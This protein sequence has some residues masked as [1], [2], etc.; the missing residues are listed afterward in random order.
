ML[1]D[2]HIQGFEW[3]EAFPTVNIKNRGIGGDISKGL[4]ARLDEVLDSKP[5][6]VFIQIGVNDIVNG[7]DPDSIIT[8]YQKI[9][10]HVQRDSPKTGIYAHSILPTDLSLPRSNESSMVRIR[11]LNNALYTLCQE[12]GAV[13]IDLFQSFEL[14][15]GLNESYDLGDGLHL[16]RNGYLKWC[17]LIEQYVLE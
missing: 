12:S 3:A 4:L 15:G 16:N 8:N 13:Y 5:L 14:S 1:G 6:K 11:N 2:S 10:E 17:A 7:Y 9:I